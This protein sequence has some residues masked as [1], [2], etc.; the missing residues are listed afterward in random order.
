M[1]QLSHNSASPL[2][3]NGRILSRLLIAIGLSCFFIS[4]FQ[5]SL[6]TSGEE[7]RGY[8]VLTIGWIGLVIFQFAWFANPLNLLAF[9]LLSQQ[10]RVSLLLSFLAFLLASQTF[11]FAEI[12]IGLN[13]DKIYIKELGLGF[14]FWYLAQGLFLISIF[15]EVIRR[16]HKT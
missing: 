6:F 7:I 2:R 3:F 16:K 15:V 8:W 14:Y 5:T 10:P 4:L 13:Q 9:L 1:H 11:S 12:P